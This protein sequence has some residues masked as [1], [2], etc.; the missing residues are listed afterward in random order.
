MHTIWHTDHVINK[1][2]TRAFYEGMQAVST[3]KRTQYLPVDL[4]REPTPSISYG[5]L[6]GTGDIFKDCMRQ[7]KEWWEIDRGYFGANH[8]HG[9]YRISLN[10]LRAQYRHHDLPRDRLDALG[11]TYAPW[12]KNGKHVLLCPPTEV[13]SNFLGVEE[14]WSNLLKNKIRDW[15]KISQLEGREIRV[16]EKDSKTP[17]SED[18]KDC[19]CVITYNSNV[20]IDALRAGIPAIGVDYGAEIR[21][22][23][24]L[25]VIESNGL[26]IYQSDRESLFRYLS[27]CQFT[28]DEM[29]SGYAWEKCQE[30]QRYA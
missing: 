20:A 4:Y 14:Y 21:S 24:H 8:F 16:R 18:L 19:H 1:T 6:R 12:Q 29:R 28:L 3:T 23:N 15:E 2:V 17:L 30:I 7:G 13:V 22:W 5:I 26:D 9:Y 11:I 27:Y 10:G 25:G